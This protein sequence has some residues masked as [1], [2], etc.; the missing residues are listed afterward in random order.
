MTNPLSDVQLQNHLAAITD[1][2][3]AGRDDIDTLIA[4]YDANSAELQQYARLIN[5]LDQVFVP[6]QPSPRFV[7]RLGQ[8]LSG[9]DTSN[10][11]VR[12]R[13]LP[14]RVQIAA[15]IALLAGFVL[16]S[17]R[18]PGSERRA[19]QHEVVSA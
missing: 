14:P 12:V 18:R 6:V 3:F 11:L 7:R 8:D 10:M 16:L 13:R 17:R 4:K 15:G 5:Q 1:A 19:E 9:A 2:L